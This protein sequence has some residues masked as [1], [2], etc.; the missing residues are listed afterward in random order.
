[1]T[2]EL[3]A[4]GWEAYEFHDR[5]E[6][7]V[8]I[9]SFAEVGP[10]AGRPAGPTPEVQQIVETFGAAYDTPAD[11][12]SGIGNDSTTQQRVHAEGAGI[13]HEAHRPAEPN[14]A[15]PESQARENLQRQR[16]KEEHLERVIP[17]DVYPTAIEVPKRSISS[18]YAG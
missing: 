11:P 1:M 10:R 3:R 7:I 14:R 9:G 8:T 5:T 13:Q 12:L 16:Q 4:H 17:L 18:A 6:S 2:E 15:R